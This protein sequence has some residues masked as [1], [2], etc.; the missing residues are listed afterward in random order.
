LQRGLTKPFQGDSIVFDNA[1]PAGVH[2]SELVHCIDITMIG[3]LLKTCDGLAIV[4]EDPLRFLSIQAVSGARLRRTCC[5][6]GAAGAIR[7]CR[8]E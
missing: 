5:Q 6:Y 4:K 3:F 8:T 7:D 1:P 2:D